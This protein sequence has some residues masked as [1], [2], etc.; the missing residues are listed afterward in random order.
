[1]NGVNVISHD[2]GVNIV[3]AIKRMTDV[4]GKGQQKAGTIYGF[5]VSGS[6]ADPASKITYLMDAVGMT[7]ALKA[8]NIAYLCIFSTY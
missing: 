8:E 7:K 5:N 6:V 3:S 4:I 2:D 1:M